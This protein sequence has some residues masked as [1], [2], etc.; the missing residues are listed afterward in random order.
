VAQI[1]DRCP[2]DYDPLQGDRDFDFIGDACDVCPDVSDPQQADSDLDGAGDACDCATDDETTFA[3]PGAVSGLTLDSLGNGSVKLEW[4]SLA[5]TSGSSV[6][7]DVV[8]GTLSDLRVAGSFVNATCS[9]MATPLPTVTLGGV[10]AS[11]DAEWYLVRGRNACGFSSFDSGGVGQAGS[12][13]PEIEVATLSCGVC[14]HDRCTE[15]LPLNPG[16]GSCIDQICDADPF[17]CE[18][19]WDQFCVNQV[20]SVCNILDCRQEVGSCEH[21]QCE[22]GLPMTS[23]CDA[24]YSNCVAQ[25]CAVD[26]F[27]CTNAWDQICVD[28]VQSVCGLICE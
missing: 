25:I 26:Q 28:Q 15:G 17:C 23:G 9:V 24:A 16:C 4:P 2:D 19:A 22:L 18:N 10:P 7:Y 3:T 11:G 14:E 13:D 1:C 21:S 8:S 5:G 27:C 6:V 12:R 20:Q